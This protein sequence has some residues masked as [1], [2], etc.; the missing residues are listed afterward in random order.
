MNTI[1]IAIYAYAVKILLKAHQNFL[2]YIEYIL[3]DKKV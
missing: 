3:Y 1:V 2:G